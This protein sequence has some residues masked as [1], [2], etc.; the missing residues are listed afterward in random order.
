MD[1]RFWGPSGWKLL[2]MISFN[3]EYS[4]ENS[5]VFANF[6]ETIPFIL[7]CKF[8]R[9]SLTD[10]YKKYPYRLEDNNGKEGTMNPLLDVKK[11]MY[12]IHN[13]VNGKLRAQGLY[14]SSNPTYA[15]VR[16]YYNKLLTCDWSQYMVLFWDFLFAVA[17]AHPREMM[18]HSKPMPECPKEAYTCKDECEKNKWNVL[19]FKRRRFWFRRFWAYLPGVLPGELSHKWI[20]AEK[21]NPIRLDCRRSILAWL[22]R[23]RCQLDTKFSDPYTSICKRIAT[24]SSDC[25]SKKTA[26]TCRRQTSRTKQKTHKKVL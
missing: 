1:T 18:S 24:F 21:R 8:C 25:G 4:V 14:P 6:F 15:N 12:N 22:W 7:P 26:I 10:F 3:Y 9:S 13:C 11:W 23:M 16:E 19:C 5:Y 20:T 2:H 17:Y